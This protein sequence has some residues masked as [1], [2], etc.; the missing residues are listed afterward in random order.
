MDRAATWSRFERSPAT[1]QAPIG[2]DIGIHLDWKAHAIRGSLIYISDRA[3]PR[4]G[5]GSVRSRKH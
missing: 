5:G 3:T 2:T 1:R 4:A